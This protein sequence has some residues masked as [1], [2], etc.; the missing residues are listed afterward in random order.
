MD[1]REAPEPPVNWQSLLGYLN[2][3]DGKSDARF[4][5]Q[6]HA[7]FRQVSE[8]TDRVAALA[9]LLHRE[10]DGLHAAGS[11]AFRDVSQARAVIDQS[12]RE[13]PP[14]YRQFH[15]D[16]L[17]HQDDAVLF[18]PFFLSRG[19]EAVLQTRAAGE[20][21]IVAAA[22]NRLNDYVGY[23]PVP[24][25]ETR[26]GVDYFPH[27][28]VRP[29]PLYLKGVGV[30]AG[31]YQAILVEALQI[32]RETPSDLLDEA[33][34][35]PDALEELALDPRAYDHNHPANRRPNYVFGEWDPHHID[36]RGRFTRF[37]VRQI[38]LDLLAKR[39][40]ERTLEFK[41]DAA[42][43]S[44]VATFSV[45]FVDDGDRRFESAAVLA[46]TMLMASMLC[47]SGPAAHES[48]TTLANLVPRIARFRDEYYDRLIER[49]H[50][51]RGDR[52]REDAVKSRQPFGGVRQSLNQALAQDRALHMQ[53]RHLAVIFALLGY[54]EE[55]RQR[56]AN[57]NAPGVRFVIEARIR[58]TEAA[59][60]CH[61]GK[62]ADAL[63]LLEDTAGL[64]RR[65]IDC[66]AL[67][68]P[69]N[70]LGFQ[71][72]YPLFQSREDSVHDPRIDELLS[73]MS[74]LFEGFSTV[75]IESAAR[76]DAATRGRAL[77]V[78]Q[79]LADWWDK[80]ATTEVSD[81]RRVH[82]G[83]AVESADHV[84]AALVKW[85]Q[86]GVTG[87]S[88]SVA[89]WREHLEGF[90]APAA[91][92][93]VVAALL[94]RHDYPASMALLMAWL[95]QAPGVPLGEGDFSFHDL[96]VQWLKRAA[97]RGDETAR[98]VPRF[99]ELLEA[100]A[101]NYW[102]TPQLEGVVT[103]QSEGGDDTFEAAYEGVTFEDS[104]DDGNEGSL[105]GDESELRPFSLQEQAEGLRERLRF[106]STVAEL[107][108][109]AGTA[110]SSGLAAT[111]AKTAQER[112]G[113]LDE[114]TNRLNA[115]PLPT[116]DATS[117]ESSVEFDQRR[118]TKE[119]LLEDAIGAS[120]AFRQ[121]LR[122]LAA[123]PKAVKGQP[124]WERSAGRLL[125]LLKSNDAEA[126]QRA[127]RDV[128]PD[129]A[130]EP[131]LYVPVGAGGDPRQVLRARNAQA[132]LQTF[133]ERLPHLGLLRES[134]QLTRIA[135]RMEQ[136]SPPEGRRVT[137]FDRL[138]PVGL[139]AS[140]E[141]LIDSLERASPEPDGEV[142]LDMLNHLTRPYLKLW[143]KHSQSLRLSVLETVQG[144]SE[145]QQIETLIGKYGK[146]LLTAQVLNLA[147]LRAILHRG[148]EDWIDQL[149]KLDEPPENFL[150]AID[151][152]LPKAQAVR[153]LEVI[154]QSVVEN[155]DEYRDYNTTTTQSDYGN[156]LFIL[157]DFLRLKSAYERDNWRLR[158]L[159]LTHEVLCRRNRT[160]DAARWQ[161]VISAYFRAQSEQHL[162]ELGRLE[163]RHGIK[164]RTVRERLE[165]RFVSSLAQDRLAAQLPSLWNAARKPGS[166]VTPLLLQFNESLNWF[167][168]NPV[169]AGLETPTWIR[170]LER[171]MVRIRQR[172]LQPPSTELPP[173]P[174]PQLRRQFGSDWEDAD[175]LV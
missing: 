165:E 18:A 29:I 15:A 28:K 162:Q 40:A 131:L 95:S 101:E 116:P 96:A 100:N 48:A 62:P 54:P 81:V 63:P 159:L 120:L 121:A 149:P 66:G 122:S 46:G 136:N 31:P 9:A 76:G 166:D 117:F 141:T 134:Y 61:Q 142:V 26:A 56:S 70:I 80:F 108:R 128:L 155:Y 135:R 20:S 43:R 75:V 133:M 123:V 85:R 82:G 77:E 47:G 1:A 97:A 67:V 33:Q 106:L 10:L 21:D 73:I 170:R 17:A 65:G 137:E 83:E 68:D 16:L 86:A 140:I 99:F 69:W 25:L 160:A 153:L 64:I 139:R 12:L 114:L 164:L 6:W 93:R 72:L 2:F 157:L 89:F 59:L 36:S 148:V 171:E 35:Q 143:L 118:E 14:A 52:L 156:N 124:R 34:F 154:L 55:S 24:V 87:T 173:P 161:E 104:T 174:L 53:E 50:G 130:G 13:L 138:F 125:Q 127:L 102:M 103:G 23:R 119:S 107:I 172:E 78:M 175:D 168:A 110:L 92:S 111:L 146:E 22:V 109:A 49:T 91:F 44:L 7:A 163:G 158:P 27:E 37:V 4:Q 60:A 113:E 58:L 132:I 30:A 8:E 151:R 45:P 129:F 112:L 94:D 88:A 145:W 90:R 42:T 167:T 19:V 39:A 57:V 38:I 105:V 3:S 115:V 71:G 126:V 152:G 41:V 147:N 169:G 84:A 11:P 144:S 32:L 51:P 79:A 150:A 5:Q 98:L 74:E